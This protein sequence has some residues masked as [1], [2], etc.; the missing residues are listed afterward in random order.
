MT[1]DLGPGNASQP[2]LLIGIIWGACDTEAWVP[3]SGIL[4]SLVWGYILGIRLLKLARYEGYGKVIKAIMVRAF[5][6]SFGFWRLEFGSTLLCVRQSLISERWLS[7][8]L[9]A[10]RT[11]S[12]LL[13]GLKWSL[14]SIAW[15][16]IPSLT[17]VCRM[18]FFFAHCGDLLRWVQLKSWAEALNKNSL[19]VWVGTVCQVLLGVLCHINHFIL[20]PVL[21]KRFYWAHFNGKETEIQRN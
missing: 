2:W 15:G 18:K 4:I 5:P 16:F 7:G 3:P 20:T 10:F 12:K 13:S 14:W 6:G 11:S 9:A 8:R 1:F 19:R 17:F 21:R